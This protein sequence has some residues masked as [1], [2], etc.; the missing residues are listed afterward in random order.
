MTTRTRLDESG[1]G[2]IVRATMLTTA[3]TIA[4]ALFGLLRDLLIAGF[5]G[6]T[7][8]TD[9][10]LVA[11]TVPE[12]ASPLLIEGAMASLMIPIFVRGI[13]EGRGLSGVVAATLPRITALLAVATVLVVVAAPILVHTLAPGVA[14]PALAVRCT[15]VTAVTVVAFGLA[16]YIGAALRSTHSFGWP[17]AIYIAYNIGILGAMAVLRVPLGVFAVAVG[18]A[19]GG[20]LMV[21]VQL[22]S[23]VRRLERR[24][25]PAARTWT[26]RVALGAFIPI[27]T[28]TVLRQG[29]V[30]IERF[31][32][33]GLPPGTISHLNYAQK[34]AQVPMVLSLMVATVTFPMLARRA[35]AGDDAGSH[36]RMTWDVRIVSAIVLAAAAYVVAFA[37]PIIKVLFERGAFTASDTGA[38]ATIMRVYTL[39]L[40]GQSIVVVLSR[41][42]FSHG[43]SLWYPAMVM[44]VGLVV[45]AAVSVATLPAWHAVA[46]PAGN[47][48][49]ITVTALLMVAGLRPVTVSTVRRVRASAASGARLVLAVARLV[50]MAGAAG[51]IGWLLSRLMQDQPAAVTAIAGAVVVASAYL[52]FGAVTG[53]EETR[54][55]YTLMR[56]ARHAT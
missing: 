25:G 1:T 54:S 24:S 11:W 56:K 36:E 43:R 9:A 35:A 39:G 4:G 38:T 52:F 34:V 53:A 7:G 46:I 3:L 50:G 45:T 18:I 32:G 27:A 5:F 2:L 31:L 28:Y 55:L 14:D 13:S 47:A 12:T 21:A 17:A 51:T 10:F 8:Q 29:Q 40:L 33:S 49:G 30:F 48:A 42:Y 6:A 20:V 37:S 16:G 44:W 41:S 19:V 23:F 22:P 15:Q 26:S